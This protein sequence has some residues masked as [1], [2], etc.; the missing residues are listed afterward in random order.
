MRVVDLT[1]QS[2]GYRLNIL[3]VRVWKDRCQLVAKNGHGHWETLGAPRPLPVHV[4]ARLEDIGSDALI[5]TAYQ[6]DREKP[7]SDLRE[8]LAQKRPFEEVMSEAVREGA[9]SLR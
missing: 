8:V 7:G 9:P 4:P 1:N 6:Y 3:G 2:I 5:Q